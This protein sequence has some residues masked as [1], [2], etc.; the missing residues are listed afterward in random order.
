LISKNKTNN[1]SLQMASKTKLSLVSLVA[2]IVA[3]AGLTIATTMHVLAPTYA[4]K[5]PQS[6]F[7]QAA[8][9]FGTTGQMGTHSRANGDF[10]GSTPPFNSDGQPGREGIG[11]VA[12]GS[13]LSVGELGCAL[14]Q[15]AG[16]SGC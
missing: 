6:G 11:N 5:T 8:S 4:Q 2:L 16:F 15:L 10:P 14:D 7:G 1:S 13:G 3:T 9:D 12:K